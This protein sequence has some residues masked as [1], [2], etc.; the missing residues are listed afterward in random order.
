M[1]NSD[2]AWLRYAELQL[3]SRKSQNFNDYAW[4]IESALN[5]LLNAVET[6]TVPSNP[7]DLDAALSRAIASGARLC[8]SRSLAVKKWVLPSELISTHTAEANI[9]LAWI[10]G[11]VKGKILLDAGLGYTDRE[12]ANRHASTPGAVRVRLSRLRLKLAAQRHSESHPVARRNIAHPISE[13][14]SVDPQV[15]NQAA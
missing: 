6:G 15:A 7:A 2:Y 12:I 4:G 10:A 9:E 1:S 11:A 13:A 14:P 5:F 8:R 3:R